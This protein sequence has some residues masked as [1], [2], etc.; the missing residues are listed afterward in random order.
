[1][2][3]STRSSVLS[4]ILVESAHMRFGFMR[5]SWKIDVFGVCM[6]T[7]FKTS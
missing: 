1:M 6:L 4:W 3:G 2:G 5:F 7:Y